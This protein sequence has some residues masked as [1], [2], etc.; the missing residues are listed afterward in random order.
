MT[1]FV[2]F[3]KNYVNFS[4]RT[5]RRGYWMAYLFYFL[6]SLIIFI[7]SSNI[8]VGPQT[9][10]LEISSIQL[11]DGSVFDGIRV[12]VSILYSIWILGTILP[13]LA[14]SVRRLRDAGKSWAWLFINF[15]PFIGVIIYIVLLCKPSVSDDGTSVV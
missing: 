10:I 14:M 4:D 12:T 8:T 11:N 2:N 3:W 6:S 7:I 13:V 5:T 15:I 1:E 9:T